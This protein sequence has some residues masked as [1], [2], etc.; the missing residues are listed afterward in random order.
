VCIHLSFQKDLRPHFLYK[1]PLFSLFNPITWSRSNMKT[2]LL[3]SIAAASSAYATELIARQET[4]SNWTVGQT[5]QTS[6]GAVSGHAAS[7]QTAVSEYL[8][9]PF[10]LPPIGDLRFEAPV[11]F[12][13]NSPLAGSKFVCILGSGVGN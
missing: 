8:G 1:L 10:A 9:I 13:G 6:S 12:T 4:A 7:N 2:S 3:F 5:V 11:K